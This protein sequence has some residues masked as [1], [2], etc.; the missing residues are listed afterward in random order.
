MAVRVA[1]R[2]PPALQALLCQARPC[3]SSWLRALEEDLKWFVTAGGDDTRLS[4]RTLPQWWAAFRIEPLAFR[5]AFLRVA[6]SASVRQ[7]GA[8]AITV[9]QRA[10]VEQHPC[11]LC[12]NVFATRQ[13]FA[14][15]DFK[16]HGNSA[17]VRWHVSTTFCPVCLLEFHARDHVI[18]HYGQSSVCRCNLLLGQPR[19]SSEEFEGLQA[20]A[21]AQ[22]KALK[23][24]G[25]S[26]FY[27]A[28][29]CFRLHGPL[30]SSVSPDADPRGHPLGHGRKWHS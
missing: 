4:G 25:R 9:A 21:A 23:A 27:A 1:S 16:A 17:A 19:L 5:K 20:C 3:P 8:W 6:R 2:A 13:A 12:E 22:V 10:L 24:C 15:H 30:P 11:H 29:P 28:L 18:A 26:R 14:V 7:T